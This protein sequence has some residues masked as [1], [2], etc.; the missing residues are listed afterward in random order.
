MSEQKLHEIRVTLETVTPLFL[1][2]ADPRGAPELRPPSLRGALRYWLR[3]A[4]GGILGDQDL[5]ALRKAET[6][7]FG[8]AGESSASV[9][10][11]A[12][13]LVH[14]APLKVLSYS[15]MCAWK[16]KDRSFGRPGIAYLFFAARGTKADQ[17][18]SGLM[19]KFSLQLQL[20][21]GAAPSELM[22]ACLALWLFA[23]LGGLGNRSRRGA[24]SLQVTDIQGELDLSGAL[25]SL[26]TR[27]NS[28]Q[29]LVKELESGLSILPRLLGA[30]SQSFCPTVLG[31]F[32]VI[33]P[34]VCRIFVLNRAYRDWQQALDEFGKVYQAFR[35]R[36]PP[37]YHVVKNEMT[38]S[39]GRLSQPVER[40][41]FGLPIPFY[42]RSLG[43]KKATLAAESHDRRASPLWVRVARLANGS[44]TIVLTWFRSQFLPP[45]EALL[46]SYGR[47]QSKSRGNVPDDRLIRVFLEGT[48][49]VKRS[50][51]REKGFS[52]LEVSYA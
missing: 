21:P 15:E 25:P 7:V 34:E 10:P 35:N 30:D 1:G 39:K 52:L 38:S 50:S 46:L 20:L 14:R 24:G 3:A 2:G 45:G 36:R 33:H 6:A 11:V 17:E 42:Y 9:S 41:A 37:D 44:H 40:A 18:R 12:V 19:G 23:R 32:D 27:A 8:S 4:L 49:S 51:L 47:E 5:D 43:G 48:D 29:E 26:V 22:K 28:P 16:E 13:R 31:A